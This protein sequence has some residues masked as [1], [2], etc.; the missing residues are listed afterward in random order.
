V[1]FDPAVEC[2]SESERRALQAERLRRVVATAYAAVP[3]Y[4]ERLDAA[5]V[6]PAAFAGLPELGRIPFTTKSD[7]R[8]HYPLGLLAVPRDRVARVH[9]SSGTRGR[10]TI[11]PYTRADVELW[12]ELCARSL[13]L[14]GAEPGDVVHVAYGY[15]LFTGGLGLHYGAERLGCTVV[16]ASAGQSQ[17]QVTLLRDLG[18]VGLACTPSYA[19]HLA[20]VAA[21]TVRLRYGVH[22]AEP[23]T[24]A[25]RARIEA[26]FGCD[27]VD[28]Y[29]LSEVVGPGV[30]CECREAK[31]G[32]HLQEDA[33]LA[34]VVDPASGQPLPEGEVGELVLTTLRKE[35]MPLLRY[36]TGDL[37]SLRRGPCRCG[38]TTARMSRV[39]GRVDD[40]LIVRGVNVFPSEIEAVVLESPHLS[41][42]YRVVLTREAALDRMEVQVEWDAAAELPAD[43]APVRAELAHRL[44]ERLGL[45]AEVTLH[46]PGS[47]P[48]SEGKAVRVLD[49]RGTA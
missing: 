7:L 44:F 40:M 49:R 9:A 34:E 22:G 45:H 38:R 19:L 43:D 11:A 8:E 1:I 18:A 32:L 41:P 10:P 2:M 30:A 28:I 24:D 3:F 12:A 27:A 48:R 47:L 33:F 13:A 17:R 21:G 42:H 25:M 39:K 4:R 36:R 23:W 35:A 31:D 46:G 20:E 26:A 15:G 6:A 16:P 29:G 14:A 5:G 37:C